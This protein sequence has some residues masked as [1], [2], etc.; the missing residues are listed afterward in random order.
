MS[1]A[2]PPVLVSAYA[3]SPAHQ[4]WEP[5]LE[6]RLLSGLCAMPGVAGLEVPWMGGVHPHDDQW[7]LA[8]VPAGAQ[9]ALTP[10]PWVM[11]RATKDSH[12]G[13]AS[14]DAEGRRAAVEDLRA[15]AKDVERLAG[16]SAA[17][18]T[19]VSLHTAPRG[20]GSAPA[21]ARSIDEIAAWDWQGARLVVEHCDAAVGHRFEKGF[22]RLDE[23]IDVIAASGAILGVWL[24]WG[25]SMVE[26]RDADAVT[27]QIARVAATGLLTGLTLSGTADTDGP[28]GSAW[29]DAHLPLAAADPQSG[30]LLDSD[31]VRAA[32]S[33]AGPVEALGL[34]VSRRPA[35]STAEDVLRTVEDNLR[36]TRDSVGHDTVP[37][38]RRG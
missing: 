34:K 8:H 27:V 31:H 3:A 37:G 6:A 22:L 14:A 7:F 21:L 13:I 19:Y 25:R 20:G 9:L 24:N 32:L 15:V 28:Y 2:L 33:A 4:S 10:L 18:V 12:Y 30:S 5:Q 17:R 26:L 16:V 29:A 38:H 36:A 1:S 23:E 11:A 35:D